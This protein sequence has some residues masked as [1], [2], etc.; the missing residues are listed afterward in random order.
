MGQRS[1][2]SL[3]SPEFRFLLVV[4]CVYCSP[5]WY[6]GTIDELCEYLCN[7]SKQVYDSLIFGCRIHVMCVDGSFEYPV[8]HGPVMGVVS[9]QHSSILLLYVGMKLNTSQ[10]SAR[11]FGVIKHGNWQSQCMD[12]FPIFS[13]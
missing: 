7:S 12:Y 13:H 2:S 6:V 5:R 8:F 4:C 11:A 10:C 9:T 3:H 1:L